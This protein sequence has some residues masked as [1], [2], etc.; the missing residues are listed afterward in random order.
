MTEQVETPVVL[1]AQ[2]LLSTV[3]TG[4]KQYK[5]LDVVVSAL[6]LD[7]VAQDS[8]LTDINNTV[9]K[10]YLSGKKTG[11]A[12]WST[13]TKTIVVAL[14]GYEN[15]AW[16]KTLDGSLLAPTGTLA[17]VVQTIGDRKRTQKHVPIS[18]LFLPV[19]GA[20]SLGDASASINSSAESNKQ[21]GAIVTDLTGHIFMAA[22]SNPT[23]TWE[24]LTDLTNDIMPTGV[25]PDF[26]SGVTGQRSR[27]R[28]V[29][30]SALP[31]PVVESAV[32]ADA[33]SAFNIARF[34]GKQLGAMYATYTG[35]V[36]NIMVALGSAPTDKWV[37]MSNGSEVTPA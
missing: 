14:N 13:Q 12:L 22:G 37:R 6:V 3:Q 28:Q 27:S 2:P 25:V 11:A 24:N 5:H 4:D 26:V 31:L 9:N 18:S 34:S 7:S 35:S 19:I 20:N 21:K 23:D 16:V 8:M 1:S 32:L 10:S 33:S 29:Q 15:G 30:M 36:L 17:P